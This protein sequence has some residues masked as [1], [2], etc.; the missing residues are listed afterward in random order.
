MKVFLLGLDGMTLRIVEPYVKA[1]LLPNFKKIMEQGC[2]GILRSTIPAITGPGWVSL[3]TGKNPGKHG[4]YEFRKRQ[5]YKTELITKCTSPHAEPIWKILSRN[6]EKVTIASVPFTY[7]PDEVNGIMISGLMTPGVNTDFVFPHQLKHDI[8]ELIPD[9]TIDIDLELYLHS[10]DTG[11]LL[12]EVVRVTEQDRK[13]MNYLLEKTPSGLFFVA[14]TGP[15]RIQHFLWDEIV[16]MNAECVQYYKLIDDI[17][18]DILQKMDDDAVLFVAS[19]HG[20]AG[21]TRGFYINNFLQNLGLLRVQGGSKTKNVLAKMN[22]S[23]TSFRWFIKKVGLLSLKSLLPSAFLRHIRGF[24]PARGVLENEIDWQNTKACSLLIHGMVFINLK[25]REPAGI[26]EEEQYDQLCDMITEELLK[27][28]DP[29]TNKNVINAVFRTDQLYSLQ[30]TSDSPDLIVVANEGYSINESIGGDILGENRVANRCRTGDHDTNGLFLAY[31]NVI[32]S[33]Q[34][35]ADIYD[36]MPTI[37]YLM[38]KPI[39]EDVD[40]HVLN[41]IISDDFVKENEIRF[42]KTT[43]YEHSNE[44]ALNEDETEQMQRQLRS[45]G[46]LE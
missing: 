36:I 39:P 46:Y 38:G 29:Q 16:S 4:V 13:L 6:G 42:E 30:C 17:L 3:A 10:K 20:F 5:G 8:F 33:K 22:I 34:V 9:Y 11:A 40:G 2:Y 25:G 1:D 14:F 37:L 15:D 35:D 27:L 32:K 31:G 19:D 45:L 21:A 26:V 41:E 7:P 24:L 43:S 44:T 23:T 12:N 18:G 28:K